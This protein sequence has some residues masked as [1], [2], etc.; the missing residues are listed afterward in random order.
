MSRGWEMDIT[1]D[2][3]GLPAKISGRAESLSGEQRMVLLVKERRPAS[4]MQASGL[5]LDIPAGF[6][7]YSLD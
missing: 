3:S 7:V 1:Y 6:T 5:G 4:S 2:E